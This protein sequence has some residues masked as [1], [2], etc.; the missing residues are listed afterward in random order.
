[1][2]I[3]LLCWNLWG[4]GGVICVLNDL[5]DYV[6]L[7]LRIHVFSTACHKRFI[8]LCADIYKEILSVVYLR[9]TTLIFMFLFLRLVLNYLSTYLFFSRHYW[10]WC[11][12]VLRHRNYRK[13][14]KKCIYKSIYSYRVG[15]WK[16]LLYSLHS[17]LFI[18]M[19]WLNAGFS[20][21]TPA[22][23]CLRD[24]SVHVRSSTTHHN[25]PEAVHLL[26]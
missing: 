9:C 21:C 16:A 6:C 5:V 22:L 18:K 14:A 2:F 7:P 26:D 1:M 19:H 20:L 12:S 17:C 15:G 8:C 24:R 11:H 13:A 25:E 10:K 23:T 3:K 4:G